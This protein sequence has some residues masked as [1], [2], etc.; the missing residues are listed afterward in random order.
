M[1]GVNRYGDLISVS[2]NLH[3]TLLTRIDIG[4]YNGTTQM[5]KVCA[6]TTI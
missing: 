2:S 3:G 5:I 6:E 1:K 4:V